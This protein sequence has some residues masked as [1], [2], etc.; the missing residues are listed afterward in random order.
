MKL[1]RTSAL[2][3][4]VVAMRKAGRP[5]L[6]MLGAKTNAWQQNSLRNFQILWNETVLLIE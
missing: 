3:M 2:G 5:K 4:F 6:R 1:T